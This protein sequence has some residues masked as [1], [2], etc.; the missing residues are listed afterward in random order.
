MSTELTH[1]VFASAIHCAC[2][3]SPSGTLFL[4]LDITIT[5]V[6]ITGWSEHLP[7]PSRW[8]TKGDGEKEDTMKKRYVDASRLRKMK[9]LKISERLS[10][11][12]YTFLKFIATWMLVLL[13]DFL[14]EFRLEYLWP[15]WL[16][17]GSVYTTFHCHGLVIC[18][19]F[20]CAAFTLD[21]FCL[22]FVPLHWL[23]FVAS[24]YV[25]FNY[26]WHTEKGIC[27]STVSLWIFLV[28]TEASLRLKDLKTSHANLSHLFAAHCI[29]YPVVYLGFDATCYFTNIFK[30]RIQKAV[31]S[32]NDFHMHLLQHSLPPGSPLYPRTT[33]DNGSSRWKSKSESSQYQ[34]QNGAVL[35][36]DESSTTDC[37]QICSEERVVEKA[38][39]EIRS[40]EPNRKLLLSKG[41]SSESREALRN[42]LDSSTT[43]EK[44]PLEEQASK[45]A[46]AV[47]NLSPKVR[48]ANTATLSPPAGRMEKKQRSC[49]KTVSPIRDG[50][51]AVT[52]NQHAEQLS[53]LEQEL[54]KLRGELQVS[55]HGEQELRSHICNLTNSERSL[56]PEVALLRQSNMLLQSKIMCL[57]KTKQ[58]DK[59]TSAMLEKKTRAE[60]EARL[61][62]ER[63]VAELL[64]HR[65]D[66]AARTMT[67]S[68]QENTESQM[69]RKR[70]KDLEAEYKQLQLQYQVQESRVLDLENDVEALGKYR[71][72][73]KDTDLLLS[74]L[75][76][77]QDKAQHLE[78]NL[79]AETR[80]KLDLFSA[81]GDAR[82]Q[83]EI[84]QDKLLR[85]DKEISSMKQK[86]AEVMA[87]SPGV[88]YVTPRPP[89]PQYLTKLLSS[90]RYMLNPR[91]LMYQCLKK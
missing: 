80:I 74:T 17:F 82:R 57:N 89:V 13:A 47:K 15:C 73:E 79:S 81:L 49:G 14:L 42:G 25:V 59:Q 11:S 87:V 39:Q 28:Y 29:G 62:L 32:D 48:R 91:A 23:F 30:L 18:V 26:I 24:T 78:Y 40:A 58:R 76:A 75:S 33:V 56:R 35:P 69:L 86:I 71:V 5:I 2:A 61:L 44:L 51:A 37:L 6:I 90:E 20:V 83:L 67:T 19:V 9:K 16:F 54:R 63:Q 52:Q 84:A 55:R 43:P 4:F 3:A 8:K 31:Q 66:E 85:Q 1:G 88:T 41:S 50:S 77:L 22:I 72:V 53:R 65:P 7:L 68:R 46:R 45:A 21:I 38:T 10:E 36:Q 64:V 12:A 60:T 27:I 70:V 34:Y